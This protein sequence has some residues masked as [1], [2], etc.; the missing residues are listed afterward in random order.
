MKWNYKTDNDT[1]I[2]YFLSQAFFI[3]SYFVYQ[4]QGLSLWN[5]K[6]KKDQE[7]DQEM[8]PTHLLVLSFSFYMIFTIISSW[9]FIKL[10]SGMSCPT[11]Q[12]LMPYR[13][14][15]ESHLKHFRCLC[16]ILRFVHYIFPLLLLH[17]VPSYEILYW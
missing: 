11:F 2:L 17:S 13:H 3:I 5:F 16:G 4:T 14:S 7:K 15:E 9:S 6:F 8:Y 10:S 1:Q 12:I